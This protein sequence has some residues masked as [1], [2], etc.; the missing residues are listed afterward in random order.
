V[1]RL[2]LPVRMRMRGPVVAAVLGALAVV[3]WATPA[4]A[5]AAVTAS[6]PAQGAHLAKIPHTV[7]INFDQPVQPDDGGLVVL[8][9]SGQQVQVASSHPSPGT[10]SATLPASLGSGAYVSDYTVTSVDGHVVSGGIVF[11]VGHVKA[12]A[13]TALARPRTSFTNWVDDFGQFL[14]YLGVLVASGLA[15][16]LAF[17]LRGGG[18][19]R[20]LRRWTYAA[21]VVG[22]IGMAV[23]G[24]AQSALTGGG[25]SAVTHW[26]IDTQSFGGKFGEQCGAQLV[27]LAACLVSLHLR[28]TMSRQFAAFYGLLV[29]AGAFVLF[30]HALVSQERWLS[31]PADIV[32][33]VFVA[34]WAGGLVGLVTVLRSRTRMALLAGQFR[35]AGAGDEAAGAVGA[36]ASSGLTRAVGAGTST[37]LLERPAPAATPS[38][39]PDGAGRDDA[40]GTLLADTA[41]VVGRFSTMAGISFAGILVAGTLLA[42]V[43]VGS[44]TNLFETGYGQLLL[45]KIALVGLL[46]VLAWYNRYLL[47][48]GLL[49]AAAATR[50]AALA[51]GWQRLVSTVRLEA[52]GMVAILGVTAVLANGTPSNGASSPPPVPFTQTQSFDGGHVTLHIT[53]NAALV[54]DWTV[55][56]TDPDGVSANLAESVSVYLVLP[57]QNVGPIETDMHKVGVGR[58][59]LTNSPNPPIVGKWQIVLQVQVSEFSQPDVSF[60][61]T[62]Q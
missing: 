51:R 60:V 24:A 59:V 4:A 56:F 48:P 14:V 12:G 18:E 31:I 45:L 16:F 26:S 37:A 40:D 35:S 17:V 34:M 49:S 29:T 11:L 57:S 9:S 36:G 50:P 61:D 42:I 27:G 20:R 1:K 32:H 8:N 28:R 62:V 19:I 13:I 21:T 46:L 7:T 39:R 10:L 58:F 38:G 53:P 3:V 43:E 15:F 6:S 52:F 25:F 30:G 41:G 47:L 2:R 44:V 33:V 22:I 23:T 5:H 54:N 55:Q